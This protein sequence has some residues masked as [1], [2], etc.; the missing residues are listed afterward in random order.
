MSRTSS[1]CTTRARPAPDLLGD[2]ELYD[3]ENDSTRK[4]TVT[5]SSLRTYR[6]FSPSTSSESPRIAATMAWVA[7]RPRRRSH[8]TT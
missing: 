8:S 5:E 1:S 7:R 4:V 3:I 2:V 6:R